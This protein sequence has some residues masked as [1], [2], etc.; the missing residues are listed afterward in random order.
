MG[1]PQID[2]HQDPRCS[3]CGGDRLETRLLVPGLTPGTFICELCVEACVQ[4]IRDADA[5]VERV[6][7][8][9]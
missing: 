1:A 4:A 5:G 6:G 2:A 8:P 3:F 9:V 7:A